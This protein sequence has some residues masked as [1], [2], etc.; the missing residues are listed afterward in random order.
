MSRIVIQA[1]IED[2][3]HFTAEQRAEIIASYPEHE[4]AARTK[5][6]PQLGSG[7]VFPIDVEEILCD[8]FP[9]PEHWGQLCAIDFGYDHPSAGVKLAFNRDTDEL[10]LTACHRAREQTPMLFA[11]AVKH[12]GSWI[13][14]AW[15]HDGHQS[16]GKFGVQDQAQLAVIY[17]QHGLK[18]HLTHATFE[19]GGFGFEAGIT[20][21]LER[22]QTG[23]LQVFRELHEFQ[24]E[25]LLYHR[26]DGIVVKEHDD[27][28]SAL[29]I[30]TIMRRIAKTRAECEP[31]KRV[32]TREQSVFYQGHS[33]AWMG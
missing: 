31:K 26:K 3:E 27:I 16:G 10:Y 1:T 32:E 12:W 2:A 29:R 20:E 23:R 9:I 19:A 21:L 28:L 25:F 4:R 33:E 13:P 11:S 22:M 6:I 17:R 24:E 5:G 15:P 30:G 8:S 7:R 14:W 18:M